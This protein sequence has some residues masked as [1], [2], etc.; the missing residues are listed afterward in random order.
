MLMAVRTIAK[1]A[2]CTL[3]MSCST[4]FSGTE[5][6]AL[7]GTRRSP[8]PARGRSPQVEPYALRGDPSDIQEILRDLHSAH[9]RLIAVQEDFDAARR[10]CQ[11]DPLVKDWYK[12]VQEQA[13]KLVEE[14]RAA[15]AHR[16]KETLA[17]ARNIMNQVATLSA[18]YR[19]SGNKDYADH[20][21]DV[22]L[23]AADLPDW[24]PQHFLQTAETT[25]GMALGYDWLY[26]YLGKRDRATIRQAIIQNGLMPGLSNYEKQGWWTKLYNTNWSLVCNAGMGLGALAVADTDPELAGKVLHFSR[27]NIRNGLAGFNP[28]GAWEEGPTYWSYGSRYATLYMA[29]LESALGTDFG[30][31]DAPGLSKTGDF[32]IHFLGPTGESFNFSDSPEHVGPAPQM[33][34]WAAAFDRPMYAAHEMKVVREKATVFHLLWISTV[35][36]ARL[37]DSYPTCAMFRGVEIA[38]LRSAWNDPKATWVG[39]KGGDATANHGHLDMG[40]FVLEA[41]GKRWASDLGP[42]DYNLPDYWGPTRWTYYRCKTEGHNT[43]TLDND[44][45]ETDARARIVAFSTKPTRSY[46]VMDLSDAYRGQTRSAMR[47]IELLDGQQV[48]VQDELQ[49]RGPVDVGWGFHTTSKVDVADDGTSA[50]LQQGDVKLQVKLIE[51]AGARL[52]VAPLN[53]RAPQTAAPDVQKVIIRLPAVR[54]TRIVVLFTPL[55]SHGVPQVEPLSNWIAAAPVPARRP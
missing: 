31:R 36:D 42:E 19:L 7:R 54:Q 16:G 45:Q 53:I 34:W 28:D 13:D 22:M 1:L 51:P 5:P 47:G 48:L 11:N 41:L 15:Q 6:V 29:A 44:N 35:C 14:N 23:A 55:D 37:D 38:F 10:L 20:A 27:T 30:L 49:A 18:M 21:R 40:S 25:A 33:L 32:R 43:I 12:D 2:L 3:L 4:D 50:T 24:Q 9:P 8:A 39:F 17:D 46:A 26:D 52:Q